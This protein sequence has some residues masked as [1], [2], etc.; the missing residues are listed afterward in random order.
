MNFWWIFF[1]FLTVPILVHLFSF[2]RVRKIYF[3]SIKYISNSTAKSKSKSRVKHLAILSNRILLFGSLV[4]LIYLLLNQRPSLND[5]SYAVYFDNSLS[6]Q[7]IDGQEI[8]KRLVSDLIDKKS[9]SG[10]YIDNNQKTIINESFNVEFIPSKFSN[11]SLNQFLISDRLSNS[12]ADNYYILSDYQL[13]DL[14]AIN[15][16]VSDT[17]IQYHLLYSKE[18]NSIKN[19]AFDTLYIQPNPNDLSKLALVVE[20]SVFNMTSGNLVIKLL[21]DNSQIS[22]IVKDIS[23]LDRVEFTIPIEKHGSYQL[24]IDGDDVSFDNNFHFV[25]SE[26]TKPRVVIFDNDKN[27]FV[28]T[29]FLNKNLFELFDLSINNID[30]E[31][32]KDADLVVFNKQKEIPTSLIGQ[33]KDLDYIIFPS[34]DIKIENYEDFLKLSFTETNGELNELSLEQN[35]P[36]IKGVFDGNL[37]EGVL[38]ST[39]KAYNIAGDYEEVIRYRGGNVFLLKSN[40][41]YF[42]N[43]VLG[44]ENGFQSKALFLPILYQIAFRAA[45]RIDM[46]YYYPG[47]KLAV[48]GDV[49]DDPIRMV[50]SDLELIPSF[51]SNGN[52]IIIEIPGD[53]SAGYYHLIHKGDTIRQVAINI[54]KEESVMQSLSI[55][56][57]EDYFKDSPNVNVSKIDASNNILLASNSDISFWKYALILTLLLVMSETMLHRFLR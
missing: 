38:P 22:S 45:D 24:K 36:I 23:E 50:N 42:F 4:F 34:S 3:S 33:F 48:S 56:E 28:N 26:R 18:L 15:R 21:Q 9:N 6:S 29:V 54:P 12:L 25:I 5:E 41:S 27:G 19:V 55:N 31:I 7:V 37:D 10:I 16:L 44:G 13:Y 8:A 2:R 39:P 30:Y 57:I 14:N 20:F 43:T 32:L 47:S 49:S 1:L 17:T 11:S 52:E 35:H 46:P 51:N 53:I 40:N